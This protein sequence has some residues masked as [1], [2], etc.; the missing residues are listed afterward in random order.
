[1]FLRK[2]VDGLGLRED[3]LLRL[4]S[5]TIGKFCVM[6]L[7]GSLLAAKPGLA[8]EAKPSYRYPGGLSIDLGQLL[9]AASAL[10]YQ[11]EIR[12]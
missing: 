1:M 11:K 4:L 10:T 8:I 7:Y 6:T 5:K 12:I 3:I 9:F 2:M